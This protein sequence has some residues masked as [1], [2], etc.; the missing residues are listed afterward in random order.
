MIKH[1]LATIFV[2]LTISTNTLSFADEIAVT[3]FT[4]G[5]VISSSAVNSNFDTLANESNENDARI[6]ALEDNP[7]LSANPSVAGFNFQGYTTQ[8]FSRDNYGFV[9]N[10]YTLSQHCKQEFGADSFV[11]TSSI[12]TQLISSGDSFIAPTSETALMIFDTGKY[13]VTHSGSTSNSYARMIEPYYGEGVA[14]GVL[15]GP[16]TVYAT[17]AVGTAVCGYEEKPCPVACVASHY[18]E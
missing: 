6:S 11:L 18:A 14:Y 13:V 5:T 12:L 8:N 7:I 3:E 9:T 15:S 17:G 16:A 1:P 10:F 2:G 4:A